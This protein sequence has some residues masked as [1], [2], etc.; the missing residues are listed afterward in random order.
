MLGVVPDGTE[1]PTPACRVQEAELRARLEQRVSLL[2]S[3]LRRG[4]R[5]AEDETERAA[6][7]SALATSSSRPHLSGH[8]A[9]GPSRRD[10]SGHPGEHT[11]GTR[12]R[13][14]PGHSGECSG[15]AAAVI[16]VRRKGQRAGV[17]RPHRAVAAAAAHSAAAARPALPP[18]RHA[19]GAGRRQPHRASGR[20]WLPP[21]PRCRS[22]RS[23][24]PRSRPPAA[25]GSSAAGKG[26]RAAPWPRHRRG[27]TL[28]PFGHLL[29][30]SAAPHRHGAEPDN[31]LCPRLPQAV[32]ALTILEGSSYRPGDLPDDDEFSF[33]A[34]GPPPPRLPTTCV[35]PC[36]SARKPCMAP[37]RHSPSA[38]AL[39]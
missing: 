17:A 27:T 1:P 16:V 18:R 22:S 13:D 21:R 2:E 20:G 9:R 29:A 31:T 35:F 7:I 6:R 25:R 19:G 12:C 39:R 26:P 10:A 15:R 28:P 38:A 23:T 30:R 24:T 8:L 4:G 3:A 34:R 14:A 36:A 5:L 37:A 11:S 32:A 33:S